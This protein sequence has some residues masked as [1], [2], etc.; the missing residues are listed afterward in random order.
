MVDKEHYHLLKL[1][2]NP[3]STERFSTIKIHRKKET[4]YKEF[5]VLHQSQPEK[6]RFSWCNKDC[7]NV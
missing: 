7:L 4:L 5:R 1:K 3:N 2:D 6:Y